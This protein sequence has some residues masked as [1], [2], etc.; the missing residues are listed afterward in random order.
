MEDDNLIYIDSI[1]FPS[2]E[3]VNSYIAINNLT[4][5]PWNIFFDNGFEYMILKDITILYGNNV[6]GKSTILNLISNK[7]DAQ[8]N[9]E[10]FKD[11]HYIMSGN[12]NPF[13]DFVD[14]IQI[15]MGMMIK[16]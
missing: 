8:R 5:Y 12:I 6:S 3:E 15:K 11:I 1:K 14:M 2:K 4:T 7:I 9:S 10:L 16:V 13:N